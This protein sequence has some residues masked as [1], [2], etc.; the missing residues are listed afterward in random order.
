AKR[1]VSQSEVEPMMMPTSAVICNSFKQVIK[2]SRVVSHK[3]RNDVL[4]QF[5]ALYKIAIMHYFSITPLVSF[6]ENPQKTG[7]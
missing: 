2:L 6:A 1:M 3:Y 4:Q 7:Y 5:T